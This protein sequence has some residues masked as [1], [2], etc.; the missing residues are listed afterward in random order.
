MTMYIQTMGCETTSLQRQTGV[1]DSRYFSQLQK[2]FSLP[3]RM[4][5]I[6][7][8]PSFLAIMQRLADMEGI[9]LD[10]YENIVDLGVID[11]FKKYD[12]AI[13]D[14]DLGDQNAV[15]ISLYLNCFVKELPTLIVSAKD[16]SQ[17]C[18]ELPRCVK[19]VLRK[20]AGYRYILELAVRL[21]QTEENLM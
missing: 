7:D 16:R 17:E 6:D 5:L 11:L 3:R 8:D 10:C 9:P 20:S 21:S 13:L 18:K 19:S 1:W 14:Y 12:V 15:D 2:P 4:V